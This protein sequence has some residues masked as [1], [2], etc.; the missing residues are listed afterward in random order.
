M[1]SKM[2]K[3]PPSF[4]TS[5]SSL[6]STAQGIIAKTR[7]LISRIKKN[8]HVEAAVFN[9]VLLP[10]SKG[11][12]NLLSETRR[13][14]FLKDVSPDIAVRE[15]AEKA[16]ELFQAFKS[17]IAMDDQLFALIDAVFPQPQPQLDA[18]SKRYLV[19]VHRDQT[20]NGMSLP[21]GPQRERFRAIK[22]RLSQLEGDFHR[23]LTH[24]KS[25]GGGLWFSPEQ[26][27]GVPDKVLDRFERGQEE[28]AGLLRV[29]FSNADSFSV[30]R[31]AE[32]A[33]TRK[34]LYIAFQNMVPENVAVL[35]EAVTI[36]NEAAQLL[37]YASHAAFSTEAKM[38]KTP[39]TVDDFLKQL[40]DGLESKAKAE[41][42]RL[43]Q[44]KQDHMEANG[45]VFDGRFF[46]WDT[47]FYNSRANKATTG[48][49]QQ[50]FSEYFPL[51]TV[52]PN[53]LTMFEDLLGFHFAELR[54][55]EKEGKVWHDDV[56]VFGV[57]N[58]EDLG[59]DFVGHLYL[60]LHPREGKVGNACSLNLMP[61]SWASLLRLSCRE[62]WN[63]F[64]FHQRPLEQHTKT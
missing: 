41:V 44:L 7:E 48:F 43:K 62:P 55:E 16:T 61:V 19:K 60:D 47:S 51:E 36:R 33:E 34:N 39:E 32:S 38:A 13:V 25:G 26:L 17:E 53:M 31:Y 30:L 22:E 64:P 59:G 52:V 11:E 2:S 35:K 42:G 1:A 40:R 10:F 28:N 20:F 4:P 54:A 56:L 37:G 29:T 3:I 24:A 50:S 49:D 46:L 45:D 5:A 57:R 18:E 21:A 27:D 58:S 9:N 14:T 12:N 8:I 23:N 15:A 63:P 6:L